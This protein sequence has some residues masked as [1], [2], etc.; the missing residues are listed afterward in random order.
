[1]GTAIGA[2][3]GALSGYLA[4]RK[5]KGQKELEAS[6]AAEQARITA[7]QARLS[8]GNGGMSASKLLNA[9]SA[10]RGAAAST[11]NEQIANAMRGSAMGAGASGVQQ[12]AVANAQEAE[13]RANAV[14]LSDIRNQDLDYAQRQR[15]ALNAQKQALFQNQLTTTGMQQQNRQQLYGSIAGA[16]APGPASAQAGIEAYLK[17]LQDAKALKAAEQMTPAIPGTAPTIGG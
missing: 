11:A 16:T 13:Q 15:D 17:Q 9:Q 10:V 6:N 8:G 4:S 7:E 14:G 12:N 3:I 2:G 5:T 1:L